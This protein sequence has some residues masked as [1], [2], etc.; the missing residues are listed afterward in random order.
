MSFT[1][2]FTAIQLDGPEGWNRITGCLNL[3]VKSEKRCLGL[4]FF[5]AM[6]V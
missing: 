3:N 2:F 4:C 5:Q 1:I 6:S